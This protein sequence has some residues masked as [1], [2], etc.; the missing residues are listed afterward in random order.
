[1]TES[2]STALATR[3]FSDADIKRR[4]EAARTP[5]FGLERATSAQLNIIFLL[6][7]RYDLDVVTDITLFQGR[8]WITLDGRLRML[9]R[10][11]DFR[12]VRTRPLSAEEKANWGYAADDLV[13]EATV[14][15]ARWG[16]LT[17]RGKV[18]APEMG[19]NTPTG[20]HPT[21]MAEKRAIARAARLAF[22]QDVP[23]EADAA[24]QII[25]RTRPELVAHN[26]QRYTEIFGDGS[27]EGAVVTNGSATGEVLDPAA[28][29]LAMTENARLVEEALAV[30]AP[31]LKALRADKAWPVERITDVNRELGER[32]K[33]RQGEID[34][35]FARESGQAQF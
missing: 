28:L 5:G 27:D 31:V 22:G 6:A 30:G 12:G 35:Q 3:E 26:A 4:M 11:P 14:K 24:V 16:E 2:E 33:S 1:M 32:I 23:D 13:V 18:S 10:H 17:A 20:T 8:P 25:E 19:R 21:E 7:Q 29:D 15:T 34:R 9:R